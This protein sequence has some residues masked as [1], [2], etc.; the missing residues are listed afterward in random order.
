MIYLCRSTFWTGLFNEQTCVSQMCNVSVLVCIRCGNSS[1]FT[2]LLILWPN[3]LS[4]LYYQF[5]TEERIAYTGKLDRYGGE[6][7]QRSASDNAR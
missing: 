5:H 3:S 6:R 4:I 7:L 1:I 2:P